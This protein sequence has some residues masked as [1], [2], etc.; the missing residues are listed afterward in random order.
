MYYFHSILF[1]LCY[2][3][4][5]L[6]IHFCNVS[7]MLSGDDTWI[8]IGFLVG[9]IY[10]NNNTLVAPQKLKRIKRWT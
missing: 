10:N 1:E 7:V 4:E 6:I 2:I 3:S 9:T 8:Y 5:R